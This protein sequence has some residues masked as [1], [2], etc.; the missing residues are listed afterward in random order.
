MLPSCFVRLL[1]VGAADEN[2]WVTVAR[3]DAAVRARSL[4]RHLLETHLKRERA[5]RFGPNSGS[6]GLPRREPAVGA[7]RA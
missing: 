3:D 6:A 1:D 4:L 2:L 5:C 7:D